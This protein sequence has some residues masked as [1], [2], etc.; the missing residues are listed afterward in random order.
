MSRAVSDAST[1]AG[2]SGR[3]VGWA[4]AINLAIAGLKFAVAVVTSSTAMLAEA[5]H[6]LADCGNQVFLLLGMHLSTRGPDDEHPFGYAAERYFWSFIAALSIFS[7][8]GALSIYEGGRR[9][10]EPVTPGHQAIESPVWAF[11]V[12]G[13]SIALEL[14]S[15]VVALR[16]FRRSAAGRSLGTMLREARDPTVLT[17]LFEDTAA[18]VGLVVALGG[19][20]ASTLTANPVWDGLASIVV[21][22]V[23]A[24]VAL[25]LTRET[26][27]LLIGRSV[28]PAERDRI[29]A[30]AA[31][32]P[33]VVSVVHIRTVH[34]GPE[35]VMC[36]LKLSFTP[37]L[38]TRTL[39]ARINDL[40]ARL[41][42]ELPHLVR[43][44][45]EPGFEE[46][47]GVP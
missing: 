11:A 21:G 10:L 17:V 26:K 12:L 1:H 25:F 36:G 3:V 32:S 5:F 2:E 15:L 30:I 6:S 47:P 9:V 20:A 18:L 33:D 35:E 45:V 16:E 7:V 28:P 34:L 38:D 13:V 8:G 39:E 42:A 37:T 24:A 41:R 22:L 43:I 4:L 40:E 14:V 27:S 31:A 44:Y 23:L 46:H 19:V 29:S